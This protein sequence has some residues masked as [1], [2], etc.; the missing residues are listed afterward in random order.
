M[1]VDSVFLKSKLN[2][3]LQQV[4]QRRDTG[5]LATIIQAICLHGCTQAANF[6]K[7]L[8]VFLV[9]IRFLHAVVLHNRTA[10]QSINQQL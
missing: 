9:K 1:E 7:E 8:E 5:K 6:E 3:T 10:S 2:S 4:S